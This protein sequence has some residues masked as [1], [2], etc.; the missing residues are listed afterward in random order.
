MPEL[1]LELFSEEIPARMQGARGGGSAAARRRRAEGAGP[2]GGEA[3]AFA[4]P[5]RLA[6]V[7]EDVPE[8]SPDVSRGAEGPARRRAGAGDRGLPQGGGARLHR[9]GAG[10]QGRQE[11]RLLRRPDREAGP[12]RRGDR[13]RDGAGGRRPSFPGRSRCAGA[14]GARRWVRPLH[15]IVC[16]LDGKVVPFEIAGIKSGNAR[17]G[18]AS[19]ATSRSR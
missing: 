10:R 6:L 13:R 16:L 8:K 5:R 4:T 11:G 17:A 12:R 19:T 18:I 7:I 14:R 3:K 2:R 1:L 15:S 9:R